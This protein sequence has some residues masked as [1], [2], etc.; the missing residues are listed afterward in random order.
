MPHG[1]IEYLEILHEHGYRMT[2]QRRV[3]LGA[4]CMRPGHRSVSE[5]YYQ[6]REIDSRIDRSTAY[7]T[8]N[9]FLKLGLVNSAESPDGEKVFEIVQNP[10]HHHLI[11]RKCGKDT[12]VETHYVEPFYRELSEQ[13]HYRISMDHLIIFGL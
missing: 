5:I 8:L 3:I 11:C 7:R 13:Y 9:L 4:V 6:A 10:P 1:Y 2:S 12:E